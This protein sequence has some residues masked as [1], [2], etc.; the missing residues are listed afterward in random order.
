MHDNKLGKVNTLLMNLQYP[1]ISLIFNL[2][3][4]AYY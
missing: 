1:L 2:S 3:Y 4:P